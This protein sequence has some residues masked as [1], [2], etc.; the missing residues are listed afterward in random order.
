MV[1]VVTAQGAANLRDEPTTNGSIVGVL[2]V[3]TILIVQS[4]TADNQWYRVTIP[5][6]GSEAWIYNTLIT[7]VAGDLNAVP[8]AQ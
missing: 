5:E 6:D 3:G 7:T 1:S 8:L 2:P 4:T